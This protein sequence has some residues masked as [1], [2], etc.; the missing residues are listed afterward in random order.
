MVAY[1]IDRRHMLEKF[2]FTTYA[3]EV[4]I[5]QQIPDAEAGTSAR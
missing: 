2:F 4:N 1:N 5:S 3:R